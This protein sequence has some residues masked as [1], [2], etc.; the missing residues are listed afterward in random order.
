MLPKARLIDPLSISVPERVQTKHLQILKPAESTAAQLAEARAESFDEL[1][2]WF[3]EVMSDRDQEASQSWQ[4]TQ[5]GEQIRLFDLRERLPFSIFHEG[6]F[7]GFIELLPIW[8]RGQF[9][10]TYWI[11]SQW[12]QRG[13][14]SEAVSA[15]V[16]VA[17]DALS[18][19]L[20][21]TGHAEP[22]EGSARLARKLGFKEFARTPLACEL[23]DGSLVS[24]VAYELQNADHLR[25]PEVRWS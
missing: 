11:R 16:V 12:A 25:V 13:Y 24:G 2:P 19:R 17:F 4:A 22:N 3:H 1:W 20:V 15:M 7:I 6:K 10:L 18:A 9:R 14:G 21:T 5:L 23:P 8:R